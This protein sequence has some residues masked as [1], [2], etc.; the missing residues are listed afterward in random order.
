[1]IAFAKPPLSSKSIKEVESKQEW[2]GRII[3]VIL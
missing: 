1:M 2:K 3:N